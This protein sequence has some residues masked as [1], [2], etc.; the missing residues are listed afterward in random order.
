MSAAAVCGFW[1]EESGLAGLGW[2]LPGARSGLLLTDGAVI[3]ADCELEAD[4]KTAT[5]IL[6]ADG[7]S[8]EAA[9]KPRL[10]PSPLASDA[11]GST[12]TAPEGASCSATVR[13]D[14]GGKV[15]CEGHLTRWGSDPTAPAGI[16]RHLALPASEGG[17]LIALASAAPGTGSHAEESAAA[18]LLDPDGGRA[19]YPEAL[20]STQY[21]GRGL[22]TRAG[23]ELWGAAEDGPPMRAAGTALDGASAQDG[24]VSAAIMRTS[25]EGFEGLGSYL[26]WRA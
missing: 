16:L 26:I 15:R 6:R 8:A 24:G 11:T 4:G 14:G 20:L 19:D 9:L 2:D 21:D 7:A 1:D 17:L 12:R 13:V 3:A 23:L 10:A 5:L 25:A 22:Q 18:W